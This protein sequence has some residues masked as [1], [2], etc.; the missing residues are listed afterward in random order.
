M[1]SI[2]AMFGFYAF[3]IVTAFIFF[4][5]HA[6]AKSPINANWRGL[7]VK[8]YD[9]VAYFT[10]NKPVEGKKEFE[11]KWHGAT[12]RFANENHLNRFKADPEKYAPQYGGY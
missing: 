2:A 10:L 9:P 4:P 12:W 11:Y 7:A 3:L 5:A 1:R 6:S 8:G